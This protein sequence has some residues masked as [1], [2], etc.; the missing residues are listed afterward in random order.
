MSLRL[1][2]LCLFYCLPVV[3]VY[4]LLHCLPVVIVYLLLHCLP[5]VF[6]PGD[7]DRLATE[8]CWLRNPVSRQPA[9]QSRPTG[10]TTSYASPAT[11]ETK[12]KSCTCTCFNER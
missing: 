5:V 3:I 2:S 7:P 1:C 10:Q 8:G 6:V 11:N 4:L 12:S 9:G